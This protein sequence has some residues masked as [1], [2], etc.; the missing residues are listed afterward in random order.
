MRRLR[1]KIRRSSDEHG[2]DALVVHQVF[3][4]CE[5]IP[6]LIEGFGI[7]LAAGEYSS[8]RFNAR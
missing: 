4:D 2:E 6:T 3:S 8:L 1:G 5:R 7:Q